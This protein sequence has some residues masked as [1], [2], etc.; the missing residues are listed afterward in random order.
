MPA[1][2]R[3]SAAFYALPYPHSYRA[4]ITKS[5]IAHVKT[6]LITVGDVGQSSAGVL[7]NT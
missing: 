2:T 5:V 1:A 6:T 7:R 3:H 4:G